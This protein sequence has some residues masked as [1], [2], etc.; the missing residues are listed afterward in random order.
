MTNTH[1]LFSQSNSNYRTNEDITFEIRARN[2]S[3]KKD[4]VSIGQPVIQN[5]Q[6]LQGA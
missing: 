2:V 1:D 3:R 4:A 5:L 6:L